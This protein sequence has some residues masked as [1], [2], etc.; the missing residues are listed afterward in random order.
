M[1]VPLAQQVGETLSRA[2]VV[3]DVRTPAEF[4]KGAISGAVNIPL[5]D[6]KER[7]EIGIIYKQIGQQQ[8]IDKGLEA[9]GGRLPKF[10]S[11]FEPYRGQQIV[12]YCAR[13]GMRSGSVVS[14]LNSLGFN[15]T[16]LEGGYKGFRNYLLETL[17]TIIP[18]QL[19]VIHGRTGTG[20]TLLLDLLPNA[21]D[22]EGI[23]Q[24]RSSL[25]GGVNRNPRT[26]QQF[27][28]LLFHRL[29][30]VDASQPVWVEGE[31]RKVGDAILPD[32][33]RN[34]MEKSIC[35]LVTAPMKVRVARIIDEY[36]RHDPATMAQ[37]ETAL[38]SLTQHFGKERMEEMV[39]LLKADDLEPL[40]EVLLEEYYDPRYLHSMRNYQYS[41][42]LSSENLEACAKELQTFA[43][44]LPASPDPLANAG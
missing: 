10:V 9:V 41:L 39:A 22:L 26:Q 33:L 44:Q 17:P 40:V 16:K 18:P 31:S 19:I 32:A 38:R 27:E 21:I 13:G 43:Q 25:F 5:F 14:L 6:N 24:H 7:A 36:S 3:I 29:Q 30:E 4:A 12:V 35:V 15:A 20:K 1:T 8:A 2:D 23:A 11:T 28:A 37:L 34:T 42:E